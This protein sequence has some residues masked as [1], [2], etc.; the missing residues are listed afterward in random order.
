MASRSLPDGWRRPLHRTPCTLH[1][2][3]R[4]LEGPAPSGLPPRLQGPHY[5]GPR[6]PV[7]QPPNERLVLRG[8]M[9][10]FTCLIDTGAS[11]E[12]LWS[13]CRR[14]GSAPCLPR[15]GGKG[16]LVMTLASHNR[17]ECLFLLEKQRA[18]SSASLRTALAW[19]AFAI[20]SAGWHHC[21]M[22]VHDARKT[23]GRAE[24]QKAARH[25][26]RRTDAAPKPVET[27]LNRTED[28]EGARRGG[29]ARGACSRG[30][31]SSDTRTAPARRQFTTD[32]KKSRA[33]RM[34][35]PRRDA[36]C[37]CGSFYSSHL[38]DG[39]AARFCHHFCPRFVSVFVCVCTP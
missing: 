18:C 8:Q 13:H 17:K 27:G 36:S 4:A 37:P 23:L 33:T 24:S 25:V 20:A 3:A 5:T 12:C 34:P 29:A 16:C 26:T 11:C 38:A 7:T 15:G 10:P 9:S 35:S 31:S 1:T 39:S 28:V 6:G 19:L 32:S 2:P 30:G 22:R 21:T 14:S